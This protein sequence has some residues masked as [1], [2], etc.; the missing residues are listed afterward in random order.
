MDFDVC[1][2]TCR[3]TDEMT[4]FAY[5]KTNSKCICL[6]ENMEVYDGKMHSFQKNVKKCKD[7]HKFQYF[8]IN[9][10]GKSSSCGELYFQKEIYLP[11][12]YKVTISSFHASPII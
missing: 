10:Y 7:N 8:K 3:A 12:I 11:N 1:L 5:S 4:K 9:A 6:K 2:E